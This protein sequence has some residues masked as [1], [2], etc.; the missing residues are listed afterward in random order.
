[1]LKILLAFI[2]SQLLLGCGFEAKTTDASAELESAQSK[3]TSQKSSFNTYYLSLGSSGAFGPSKIVST[4]SNSKVT[5]CT[6]MFRFWY[7]TSWNSTPCDL[8][9]GKTVE[10]LFQQIESGISTGEFGLAE[11]HPDFGV[12]TKIYIKGPEKGLQDTVSG[13]SATIQFSYPVW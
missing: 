11:Y 1:M 9:Q 2:S 5:E 7:E 6:Q 13:L 10:K 8:S 4:V 3:W 12:P